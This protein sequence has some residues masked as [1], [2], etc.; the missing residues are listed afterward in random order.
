MVYR[1]LEAQ[2]RD[3]EE[4]KLAAGAGTQGGRTYGMSHIN[5]RNQQVRGTLA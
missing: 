2:L 4:R 1:R 3:L 5:K